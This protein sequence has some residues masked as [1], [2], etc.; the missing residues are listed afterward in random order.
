MIGEHP[1]RRDDHAPVLLRT[2]ADDERAPRLVD[3]ERR[4]P[5]DSQDQPERRVGR[6]QA[7]HLR[8]SR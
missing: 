8:R 5:N 1:E 3:L 6:A 7:V 2:V 4:P